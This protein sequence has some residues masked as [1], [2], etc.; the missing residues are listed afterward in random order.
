MVMGS[1]VILF[2]LHSARLNLG[3]YLDAISGLLLINAIHYVRNHPLSVLTLNYTLVGLIACISRWWWRRRRPLRVGVPGSGSPVHRRSI[4]RSPGQRGEPGPLVGVPVTSRH[5]G[6][7][8]C[9]PDGASVPGHVG[10]RSRWGALVWVMAPNSEALPNQGRGRR[11][12]RGIDTGAPVV[13]AP[14]AVRAGSVFLIVIDHPVGFSLAVA[15]VGIHRSSRGR[16]R[17]RRRSVLG[18][19]LSVGRLGPLPR[20]ARRIIASAW[21]RWIVLLLVGPTSGSAF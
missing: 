19:A 1:N 12:R 2:Q 14:H 21:R 9:S 13:V 4:H 10:G 17:Q 8:G 7:R 11:R 20:V 3:T 16:G 15:T 6:R 18:H 5:R